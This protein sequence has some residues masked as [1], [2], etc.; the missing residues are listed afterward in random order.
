MHRIIAGFIGAA[1]VLAFGSG[2]AFAVP[3]GPISDE[4]AVYNPDGSLSQSVTLYENG[5]AWISVPGIG[6]SEQYPGLTGEGALCPDQCV[7][8]AAGFGAA[9][10]ALAGSPDVILL[11]G[12]NFSL[13][14]F[15]GIYIDPTF[16]GTF[17]FASDANEGP[18][19][20]PHINIGCVAVG[21]LCDITDLL[22]PGAIEAGYTATFFSNGDVPVPEPI[23]LSLFGAGLA[24][25]VAFRR[26][27]KEPA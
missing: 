20:S 10:P 16:G 22:A 25:A 12:A 26:R 14:D 4:L 5:I 18:E 6:L 15:V 1:A 7:I 3:T 23:T 19:L 17:Y 21:D 13:S 27:K 8:Y 24:G 9:N 2:A 11:E